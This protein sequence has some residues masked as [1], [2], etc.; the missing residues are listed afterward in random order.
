MR[1]RRLWPVPVV[2]LVAGLVTAV[3]WVL[4]PGRVTYTVGPE[5]T[6]ILGPGD[7]DGFIDYPRALNDDMSRAV[8]AD[9]N[10]VVLIVR[11]VGPKPDGFALPLD[12]FR[13]LEMTAPPM[14]GTYFVGLFEYY[15]TR[16]LAPGTGQMKP[17]GLTEDKE[18]PP[19]RFA[20]A[21]D[22]QETVQRC[23]RRPWQPADEPEVADWLKGN[24]TP[25]A[26]MIEASR[27]P[28]YFHPLNATGS[29]AGTF[30]LIGQV[31]NT[32]QM[33]REAG[34]ALCARAMARTTA[35][36]YTAAWQD[37]MACQRLGRVI[38]TGSTFIEVR[39]G[40]A[41]VDFATKA[42]LALLGHADHPAERLR[43]WQADV[44]GLRP[45][46]AIADK[47]DV[48]DRFL[49]LDSVTAVIH[50]GGGGLELLAGLSGTPARQ[51][52][53]RERLLNL[54]ID[55]DPAFRAVNRMCDRATAA[56]RLSD[57][58]ARQAEYERIQ[59]DVAAWQTETAGVGLWTRV[60][61][62]AT[63]RGEYVGKYIVTLLFP[64]LGRIQNA[65]DR[66]EQ[67]DANLHVALALAAY[68]SDTGHYPVTLDELA[69]KHLPKVP[70]DLF[71][72][73]ALV[74]RPTAAG[75]LLYSV[76]VN[77][78][79]DGGQWT[80]DEPPGDDLVAQVPLPAPKPGVPVRRPPSGIDP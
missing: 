26:V 37:L 77:G 49:C 73:A 5:T 12:F 24:E 17:I 70:G 27:R 50:G 60:T 56:A 54:S 55:Y 32:V 3:V 79:D 61:M 52:Q 4:W 76:G 22:W 2:G 64:V 65:A 44:R 15:R 41:L 31:M 6:Y 13:W 20:S 16:L 68:R 14:Q 35:G 8:P 19:S 18:D 42:Q 25:L 47:F 23:A 46:P 7:R 34:T 80:D 11:A 45:F 43:G 57:R 66:A 9:A 10:A 40:I 59:A 63:E 21:N 38:A 29:D 74:Y 33:A 72:G 67:G 71:S 48:A 75:Y 39:V 53:A 51:T 30:R 62:S 69:P 78:R 58:A 36:E 1:L 28:K